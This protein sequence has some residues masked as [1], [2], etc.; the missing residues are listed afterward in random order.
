MTNVEDV[1]IS[2]IRIGD[3]K[4][5]LR[6]I[7]DLV[8]SIERVGLLNPVTI[9]PVE[10]CDAGDMKVG[11]QLVAGLR[12]L[13]ACA[14][15]KHDTIPAV[16][17]DLNALTAEIA[18]IDENLVRDELTE[19]ERGEQLGRRKEL[20]EVRYPDTR[21]GVSGG[22]A[23][24]GSATAKSAV[25]DIAVKTDAPERTIRQSIRRAD[26]ID[27]EVKE[28]IRHNAAIA[29][30]GVELDALASLK[31][32]EQK[33]AIKMVD[34]G[35]AAT[36]REAKAKIRPSRKKKAPET[37]MVPRDPLKAAEVLRRELSKSAQR[38]LGLALLV[39]SEVVPDA[40]KVSD[41]VQPPR[42]LVRGA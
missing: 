15:L 42:S 40:T 26:K 8:A 11:Y 5:A 41:I 16:V 18:E 38:K 30:S 1:P 4:R 17:A 14:E 23:R 35:M 33:R 19:L 32:T 39:P 25:A 6:D 28:A 34:E 2:E 27:T 7:T 21:K 3:R 20:Y 10:Y 37:F 12:R 24:Q 13:T 29:D 31:P 36:V 9:M 22:K